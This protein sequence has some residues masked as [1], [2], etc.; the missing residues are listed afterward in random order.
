MGK[1][2]AEIKDI[3]LTNY[4]ETHLRYNHYPPMPLSL[5]DTCKRAIRKADRGKMTK[6]VRLPKGATLEGHRTMAVYDVLDWLHLWDFLKYK[7]E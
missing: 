7:G 1:I 2:S 4:L 6:Q 5:V 3:Q